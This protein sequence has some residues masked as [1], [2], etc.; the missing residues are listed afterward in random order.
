MTGIAHIMSNQRPSDPPV[1]ACSCGYTKNGDENV[2]VTVLN[3]CEEP[4]CWQCG[5]GVWCSR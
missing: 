4:R 2:T 3:A 1:L 5:A